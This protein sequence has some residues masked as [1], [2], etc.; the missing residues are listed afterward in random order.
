ME[1]VLNGEPTSVD[2]DD[3]AQLV[4]DNAPSTRGV[5]VAVNQ[6][7]VPRS[8]WISTRLADGDRVEILAAAQ[9]G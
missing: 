2:Y 6:E 3:L 8:E 1:L 4:S 7:V 5:A 9:G